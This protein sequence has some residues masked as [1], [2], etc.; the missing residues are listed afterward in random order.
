MEE[1]LSDF[2]CI[3][4]MKITHIFIFPLY[5]KDE[6]I[7]TKVIRDLKSAEKILEVNGKKEHD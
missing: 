6:G 3:Y 5:A 4:S 2:L 1:E 7:K